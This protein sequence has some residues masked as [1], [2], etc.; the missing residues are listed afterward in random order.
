[1]TASLV[2]SDEIGILSEPSRKPRN[3]K[4]VPP[5]NAAEARQ[6]LPKVKT[7]IRASTIARARVFVDR[8]EDARIE[9][10]APGVGERARPG[11][12]A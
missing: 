1:M 3:F 10:R 6:I 8:R 4:P 2:G 7:L 5:L 9:R 12:W 11:S